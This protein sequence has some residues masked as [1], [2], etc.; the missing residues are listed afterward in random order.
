MVSS[1]GKQCFFIR[2]DIASPIWDKKEFSPLN[3][4]EKSIEGEM[5][6]AICWK[7]NVD[8][9]GNLKLFKE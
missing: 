8:R 1:S 2:H 7:L 4:M 6:K 5:I 9:I 3:K